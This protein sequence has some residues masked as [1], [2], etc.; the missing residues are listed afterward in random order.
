MLHFVFDSLDAG[1]VLTCECRQQSR[2]DEVERYNEL[3][4]QANA[5]AKLDDGLPSLIYGVGC[6]SANSIF[7]DVKETYHHEM[8]GALEQAYAEHVGEIVYVHVKKKKPI[9]LIVITLLELQS[10]NRKISG[11]IAIDD[12]DKCTKH[13][14]G[15][16]SQLRKR[17]KQ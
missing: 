14:R 2:G 10:R 6:E 16:I 13:A 15:R 5:Q 12:H 11:G 17:T 1:L 8:H 9:K 7:D 4:L 3:R